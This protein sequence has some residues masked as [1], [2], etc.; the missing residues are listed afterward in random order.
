MT[1]QGQ[2]TIPQGG[3]RAALGVRAGGKVRFTAWRTE[4]ALQSMPASLSISRLFGILGKPPRSATL[5]EM[6][7]AIRK[8]AVI[9]I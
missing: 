8:A 6:D 3:P 9:G 1:S 5:E 7:E 4:T 2:V